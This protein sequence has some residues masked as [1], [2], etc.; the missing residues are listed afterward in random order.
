MTLRTLLRFQNPDSSQDINDRFRGL[1]N[2]G[3]FS[4]GDVEVVT[5][6]LTVR[7]TPFATIGFDGMFVR[8]D[9]DNNILSVVADDRNY[10][11]VRQRYVASADP[12]VSVESLTEA[13]YTGDAYPDSLI[14]FAVVDVPAAATEVL[15][16]YIE[17]FERDVVDPVGR[18]AF[19]GTITST[20]GLPAA[21]A[22]VNRSGD[23]Y[24]V[25]EGSGG[26]PELWS[27]N[28]I[29]W[30][31]ITQAQTMISLL[32]THRNNLDVDSN[33]VTGNQADALLGT[34][35][36]PDINNRYITDADPRIP[37]QRE[38]DALQADPSDRSEYLPGEIL[39]SSEVNVFINS[40]KIFAAPAEKDFSG[41]VSSIELLGVEGPFYVGFGA[42]G[43]AQQFFNIW[44]RSTTPQDD[45]QELL[46]SEFQPVRITGI[47]TESSLSNELNPAL[48]DS[49]GFY[50]TTAAPLSVYI[51]VDNAADLDF[52]I[53]YG[54]RTFLGELEPNA[55][56]LRGPLFG[57]VDARVRQILES[58]VNGQF[59]DSAWDAGTS[60]G[61]VVAFDTV[62]GKFIQ[63]DVAAL[64]YPVGLR[65][66]TNNLV[67]EGLYEFTSSTAF[68]A[69][70]Q[71]YA[72]NTVAGALSTTAND[73]FIGTFY[74]DTRLLVNMNAIGISASTFI[75]GTAFPV[76]LFD[77]SLLPGEVAAFDGTDF[78]QW[79]DT[80]PNTPHPDGLRG[81]DNNIIQVG[82]FQNTSSSYIGGTR[83]YCSTASN[84]QI[85]T[86]P[87]DYFAAHAITGT[88]LLVNIIGTSNWT[89]AK[90]IFEIEHDSS[91]GVHS[92]GSS[93]TFIGIG[94]PGIAQS[95]S[96][97]SSTGMTYFDTGS[98]K[99]YHCTVGASN[100]WIEVSTFTG[101]LEITNTLEVGGNLI[102]PTGILDDGAG[103]AFDVFDHSSRHNAAG[104]D[105][106]TGLIQQISSN[107]DDGSSPITLTGAYQN[108]LSVAVDF[109]GRSG[110][111]TILCFALIYFLGDGSNGSAS[112][113]LA[114][115]GTAFAVPFGVTIVNSH[116][117]N[118]AA[119][120]E[121]DMTVNQQGYQNSVTAGPHTITV[122]AKNVSGGMDALARQLLVLD[123]GLS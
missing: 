102:L 59:D 90:T 63:A 29:A 72:H 3:V 45:D 15:A 25:T 84:G 98:G 85:S 103:D 87:N 21:T 67:A 94:T 1:L 17:F 2:K 34:T 46:N 96:L 104:A 95:N 108:L 10:I 76:G 118:D 110:N 30:V 4:G 101:P 22:N 9:D 53:G 75:P 120:Q 64:K 79:D 81:N 57:Q 113:E 12:I 97:A 23:F 54:K 24:I 50:G 86:S 44:A 26:F 47:F 69:G 5:S 40:S 28:G 93:R 68:V 14:V 6:T 39:P 99:V 60:P 33:H 121:L 105:A 82:L 78:V 107:A 92:L 74:D 119:A 20:T 36:T 56:L 122:R 91:S 32:D 42:V 62:S 66:N 51:Q 106:L 7:L 109:T 83:Y 123:L 58:S 43:T 111:S 31:N 65:G 11:V 52:S 41:G 89:S 35:S 8:E 49:N 13:Q 27:W 100:T 77:S 38:N 114:L 115:D 18:L 55:F 73:R 19:R 37:F 71:V 116:G 70:D 117:D 80:D 112:I 88:Q 48:A 16:E 61:D